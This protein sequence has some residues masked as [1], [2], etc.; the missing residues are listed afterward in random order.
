MTAST[1]TVYVINLSKLDT[2][3]SVIDNPS[4]WSV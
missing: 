3:E 2:S 1:S 4:A